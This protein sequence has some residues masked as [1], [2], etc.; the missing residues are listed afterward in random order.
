MIERLLV[1]LVLISFTFGSVQHGTTAGQPLDSE[2]T[3]DY[4]TR[5][6]EAAELSAFE[7]GEC[8][9]GLL[10]STVWGFHRSLLIN[11]AQPRLFYRASYP[12]PLPHPP[13]T[14]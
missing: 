1:V 10:V 3:A 4:Q 11:S 13:P 2:P 8:D 9:D 5:E 14:V 6:F 12:P 7:D